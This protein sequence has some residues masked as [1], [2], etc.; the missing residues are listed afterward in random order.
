[1]ARVVAGVVA[2][3]AVVVA[4]PRLWRW[5]LRTTNTQVHRINQS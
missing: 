1:M 5:Y 2:G 3:V 4:A